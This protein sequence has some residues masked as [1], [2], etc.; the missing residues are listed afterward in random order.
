MRKSAIGILLAA[1]LALTACAGSS[2]GAEPSDGGAP[3]DADLVIPLA[4][5]SDTV[6]FYPATVDG[7]QVEVVAA[8]GSDGELHTAFNT[9]QSCYDSGQGYYKL[10][11]GVL[12]CQNCGNLFSVDVLGL[13]HGGCNPIPIQPS[14]RAEDGVSLTIPLSTLE[15]AREMFS[16]LDA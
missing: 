12:E 10:V 15:G 3:R 9:C 7:V 16:Y 5:L 14:E 11:G 1:M 4:E 8:L 13:V 2:G 6:G